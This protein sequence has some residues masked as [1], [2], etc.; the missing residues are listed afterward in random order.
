I[1]KSRNED[2]ETFYIMQDKVSAGLFRRYLE[3]MKR[4]ALTPLKWD[5]YGDECPALGVFI[6]DAH[7]FATEWLQGDLPTIEQWD[8][9]AGRYEPNRGEGPY[10][11]TWK[12]EDREQFAVG[13][14]KPLE[15]GKTKKESLF[16]VRDMAGN[17]QEWTRTI[18]TFGSRK[19]AVPDLEPG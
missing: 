9:A 4:K 15:I 7:G 16:H 2:P 14:S 6:L 17:G 5:M 1:P 11:G 19:R 3:Q 12:P 18:E 8:K 10:Q 13:L